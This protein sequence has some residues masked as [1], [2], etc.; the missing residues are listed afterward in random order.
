MLIRILEPVYVSVGYYCYYYQYYYSILTA[1]TTEQH[2]A[3]D[4]STIP[5]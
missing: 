1:T 5:N 4:S 3:F 2:N